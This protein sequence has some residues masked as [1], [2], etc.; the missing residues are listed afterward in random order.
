MKAETEEREGWDKNGRGEQL[1]N[2][3]KQANVFLNSTWRQQRREFYEVQEVLNQIILS[4][5]GHLN[6]QKVF[7]K[8]G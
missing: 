8:Y 7:Q 3:R 2:L 6:L 4:N 1:E 5:L